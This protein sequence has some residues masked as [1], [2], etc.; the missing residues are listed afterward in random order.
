MCQISVMTSYPVV[1]EG[2][3][4]Q[5]VLYHDNATSGVIM[6]ENTLHRNAGSSYQRKV[7]LSS[8]P[9]LVPAH[10]RVARQSDDTCV[11]KSRPFNFVSCDGNS[12]SLTEIFCREVSLGC[13]DKQMICDKK[14]TAC[15]IDGKLKNF[16]TGCECRQ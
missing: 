3:Q 6:A 13:S 1:D 14:Y 11:D 8:F 9:R 10:V 5:D 15:T 12:S 16:V 4:K 2:E 7:S